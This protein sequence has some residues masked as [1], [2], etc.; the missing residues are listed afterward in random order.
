MLTA[1]HINR[2][3]YAFGLCVSS[4]PKQIGLRRLRSAKAFLTSNPEYAAQLIREAEFMLPRA[5]AY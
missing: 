3:R 5:Q 1:S 4:A 2:L